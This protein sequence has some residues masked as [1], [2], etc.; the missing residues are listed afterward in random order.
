MT[1]QPPTQ[2]PTLEAAVSAY[3]AELEGKN[4]SAATLTAYRT[5]LRQFLA[6][7]DETNGTIN[8]PADVRRADIAEYLTYLGRSGQSGVSRQRKLTAIR[9]LFAYLEA[10]GIIA[11]SPARSV[12]P[13]TREQREPVALRPDE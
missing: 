13:P 5:D 11:K 10:E 8:R 3:L 4:R 2:R 6:W 9:G 7:L 1:Q 12:A